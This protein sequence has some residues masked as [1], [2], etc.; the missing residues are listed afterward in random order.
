MYRAFYFTVHIFSVAILTV[1]ADPCSTA[2]FCDTFP[3]CSRDCLGASTGN[4][5]FYHA[6]GSDTTAICGGGNHN[7]DNW[8]NILK[9]AFACVASQLPGLTGCAAQEAQQAWQA[10]LELCKQLGFDI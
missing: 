4:F 2:P 7:V 10:Y 5:P 8:E 1:L 3:A 6:F 9:G